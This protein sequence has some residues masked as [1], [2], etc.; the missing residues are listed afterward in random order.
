MV[1]TDIMHV[2]V[3]VLDVE[4]L[5]SHQHIVSSNVPVVRTSLDG[6]GCLLSGIN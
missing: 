6:A 1:R 2:H 3:Y 4:P 5:C